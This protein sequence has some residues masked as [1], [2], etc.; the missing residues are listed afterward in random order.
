MLVLVLVLVLVL[1]LVCS[2]PLMIGSGRWLVLLDLMRWFAI[3]TLPGAAVG[4]GR[5]I[6]MPGGRWLAVWDLIRRLAILDLP[7]A[8][9]DL[10][11]RV[12]CQ[13]YGGGWSYICDGGDRSGSQRVML[14]WRWGD[15]RSAWR[16]RTLLLW[17]RVRPG[18]PVWTIGWRWSAPGAGWCLF[19]LVGFVS[20]QAAW[21]RFSLFCVPWVGS[22]S[23]PP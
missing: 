5:Q 23:S 19:S 20:A 21:D 14:G 2:W 9:L 16:G 18:W 7:D 3:L 10:P 12:R 1:F 11:G 17:C 6:V 4:P 8:Q 15:M 13:A 22:T